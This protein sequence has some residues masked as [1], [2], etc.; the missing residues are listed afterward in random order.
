[1][2]NNV[3][4]VNSASSKFSLSIS[5]FPQ[6]LHATLA[7]IDDEGNGL[8][9]MDEL[10]EVFTMYADMKKAA[11]SDSIAL[12]T[13]PKELRPT[14]KVFDVDGD[15]T[16]GTTELARAAEM[17]KESRNMTKRLLKVVAVLLI[18]MLALVGT[19]VGLTAHVIEE[20]KETKTDASGVTFAK[21][22][23]K[24]VSNAALKN[25]M[26][27]NMLFDADSEF[28]KGMSGQVTDFTTPDGDE[29]GYSITGYSRNQKELT[30]YTSRGDKLVVGKDRS[31]KLVDSADTLISTLSPPASSGRRLL[32]FGFA[33][34]LMTSGSFT[35]VAGSGFH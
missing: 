15:G 2:T 5:Q 19:I 24:P 29:I 9:E 17:Y 26:A 1:M 27:I 10:T 34:S 30:L 14:L 23:N 3:M 12:S 28:L 31:V 33:G 11:K 18:I 22:T 21:G 6:S 16:V 25:N 35:M 13:L 32:M 8:L 20:A 4:P 7:E